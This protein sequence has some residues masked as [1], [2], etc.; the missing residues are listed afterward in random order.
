MQR[1]AGNDQ[2]SHDRRRAEPQERGRVLAVPCEHQRGDQRADQGACLIERLVQSE[3]PAL[4][5]LL[6]R[7]RHHRVGGG[8]AQ[9]LAGALENDEERRSLP[10]SRQRHRRHCCHLQRVTGQRDGPIGACG[11]SEASGR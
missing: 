9:R 7:A 8:I 11:G 4:A 5:D 2:H 3:R 1:H 6:A 10:A